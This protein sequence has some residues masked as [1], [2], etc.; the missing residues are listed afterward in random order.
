MGLLGPF[1]NLEGGGVENTRRENVPFR[2]IG[3]SA[4][5]QR[6]SMSWRLPERRPHGSLCPFTADPSRGSGRPR[7]SNHGGEVRPFLRGKK[8]RQTAQPDVGPIKRHDSRLQF[9]ESLWG[10]DNGGGGHTSEGDPSEDGEGSSSPI[11]YS[12]ILA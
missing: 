8:G 12:R 10:I 9:Y 3:A 11:R 6:G 4:L 5:A 1:V 7:T 2:T